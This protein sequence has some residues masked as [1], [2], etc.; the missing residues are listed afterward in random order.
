[1]L[2]GS[3]RSVSILKRKKIGRGQNKQKGTTGTFD[4]TE[5]SS[6]SFV[7]L[8]EFAFRKKDSI[9]NQLLRYRF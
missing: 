5:L 1:M 4:E 8:T 6:M 9:L 7:E 3:A 2:T